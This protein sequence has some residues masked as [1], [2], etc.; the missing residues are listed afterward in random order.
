M[1]TVQDMRVSLRM[2][3]SYCLHE[4]SGSLLD[5]LRFFVLLKVRSPNL[6]TILEMRSDIPA[7]Q[8]QQQLF[9][10]NWERSLYH[11]QDWTSNGRK[12]ALGN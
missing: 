4:L 8:H 3:I 5:L 12:W 10:Y 9:V 7:V 2:I 1:N 11:T 6:H